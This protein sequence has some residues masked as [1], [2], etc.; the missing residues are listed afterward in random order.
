MR[1]SIGS[2]KSQTQPP[3]WIEAALAWLSPHPTTSGPSRGVG[4][5]DDPLDQCHTFHCLSLFCKTA[6]VFVFHN[7]T[8]IT[9]TYM[10]LAT[11][12]FKCTVKYF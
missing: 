11:V 7:K 6:V 9:L 8:L 3:L 2:K 12:I 10:G 5:A 1:L 4:T